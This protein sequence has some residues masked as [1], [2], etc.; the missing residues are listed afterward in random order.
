MNA[1]HNPYV[2]PQANFAKSNYD[3]WR[4]G[5]LFVLRS[6]G[7]CPLRCVKCNAPITQRWHETTYY[8]RHPVWYLILLTHV[9]SYGLPA[10]P[11]VP[12]G[13]LIIGSMLVLLVA[14]LVLRR[15]I[16]FA[17]SLCATHE[18]KMWLTNL[19]LL[20]CLFLG[21]GLMLWASMLSVDI[22]SVRY[23]G[24]A[25]MGLAI[26]G[27]L[28]HAPILK[29]TNPWKKVD[30]ELVYFKGCGMAFLASLPTVHEGK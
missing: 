17:V 9:L 5:N 6:G 21:L 26:V 20:A 25:L 11:G 23:F 1:A 4:E 7:L 12:I 28:S 13:W 29:L 16:S 27:S 24:G 15:K 18:R 19:G 30:K 14:E 10:P 8:W 3:C 2:P 22:P